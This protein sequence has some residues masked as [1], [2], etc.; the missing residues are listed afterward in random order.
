MS[1]EKMTVYKLFVT[2]YCFVPTKLLVQT[3]MLLEDMSGE[4]VKI[5]VS[6]LLIQTIRSAYPLR[7]SVGVF[8]ASFLNDFVK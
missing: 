2:P 6:L 7:Y 4:M 5:P 3:A 8:L 1:S